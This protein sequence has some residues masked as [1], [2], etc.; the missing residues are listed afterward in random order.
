[1][2]CKERNYLYTLCCVS[3]T[4]NSI[5][6]TVHRRRNRCSVGEDN[7]HWFTS[8]LQSK[9]SVESRARSDILKVEPHYN[10]RLGPPTKLI[11]S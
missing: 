11:A 5:N 7:Y 4:D 8:L 10:D 3:C 1:M 6:F 2:H 9:C